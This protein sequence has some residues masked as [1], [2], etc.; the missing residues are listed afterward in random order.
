MTVAYDFF[1]D[2]SRLTSFETNTEVI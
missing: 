2:Y 1:I